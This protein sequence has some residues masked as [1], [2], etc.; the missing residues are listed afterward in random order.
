MFSHIRSAA[1]GA[2]LVLLATPAWALEVSKSIDLQTSPAQ[3]WKVIGDFCSIAEWHPVIASCEQ[4]EKGG[5]TYRK[6]TT[7][8]GGVLVEKLI[9]R[10]DEA[11]SYTYTI[12]ESP[13]PVVDYVSTLRVG[14][15]G[16]GARVFWSGTFSAEGASDQ[17]AIEVIAGI[18][19]AGLK[20]IKELLE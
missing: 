11:M 6:L 1:L 10:S 4:S 2:A 20:G 9:E 18:Y 8:D 15:Q 7:T 16:Y 14:T 3:V 17:Q 19:Q 12:V 5:A 13:L